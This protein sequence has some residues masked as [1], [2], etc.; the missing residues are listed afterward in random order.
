MR[1][2][3]TLTKQEILNLISEC[4]ELSMFPIADPKCNVLVVTTIDGIRQEVEEID[5]ECDSE[6]T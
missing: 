2:K 4:G 3:V 1:I 6:G 5:I